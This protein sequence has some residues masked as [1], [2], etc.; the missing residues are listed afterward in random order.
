MVLLR[1]ADVTE[2]ATPAEV[3]AGRLGDAK[4]ARLA[5]HM[6]QHGVALLTGGVVPAAILGHLAPRFEFD[7]AYRY[8]DALQ[9]VAGGDSKV[10]FTVWTQILQVDPAV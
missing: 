5:A 7:A 1:L 2:E 3:A 4:I 9:Q 8:L 10:N 6:R